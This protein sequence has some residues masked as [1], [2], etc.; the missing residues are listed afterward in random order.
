VKKEGLSIVSSMYLRING[1][2]HHPKIQQQASNPAINW[3]IPTNPNPDP[4]RTTLALA[5]IP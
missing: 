1:S 5:N 3:I 2:C 4:A